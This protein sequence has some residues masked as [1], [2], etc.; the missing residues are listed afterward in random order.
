MSANRNKSYVAVVVD[1]EGEAYEYISFARNRRNAE[2]DI[3]ASAGRWG[4]K[5]VTIRPVPVRKKQS[6]RWK[7]LV[8]SVSLGLSVMAL[9]ALLLLG[10]GAEAIVVSAASSSATAFRPP[11]DAVQTS[12]GVEFS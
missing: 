8:T 7:V 2:R 1:D 3:S 5:V 10:L 4:A 9:A 6:R 11:V 12:R